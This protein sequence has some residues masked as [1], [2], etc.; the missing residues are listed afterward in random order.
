MSEP[1]MVFTNV[2]DPV[3]AT[4]IARELI[5]KKLAACVNILPEVQ[6][7]YRWQ[8]VV[9]QATEIPLLIKTTQ[10]RY[11]ELELAIQALHPYQ[12]PEIIALPIV[13][14]LPAYLDWLA[15]ETKKE[16]HV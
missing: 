6:S 4:R 2:P 16:I 5:E 15:Q 3:I 14:G 10:D 11:V 12:V 8:G 7:M 13:A 1:L 9:E